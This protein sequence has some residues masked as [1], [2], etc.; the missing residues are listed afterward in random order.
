MSHSNFFAE[1]EKLNLEIK[2][3]TVKA[4]LSIGYGHFGGSLSITET[5]A[6][7]YGRYLKH[8]PANPKMPDRD[9]F[10]LSKGHAGPALYATLALRNFISKEDLAS[11]NANGTNL[12]SHADMNKTPGIDMTTGSL[13]QGVSCATGMAMGT[14]SNVFVI[15]GDGELQ[16]GQCWEAFQ[17]A[18]HHKLSNLIV[19]V[20]N[21]KRQLDGDLDE[22]QQSYDLQNKFDAFGFNAI[23]VNGQNINQICGA[24]EQAITSTDKPTAIIL[25]TEK[26]QGIPSIV[27]MK[28]NHHLRIDDTTRELIL[29]DLQVIEQKLEGLK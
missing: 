27:A 24:I 25:D 2:A 28:S 10:V 23:D 13:G 5:L 20:D 9:Y 1:I 21:N 26:G 18:A 12:P 4:L 19:F 15:V 17:F 3:E 7:L 16:E 14:S 22:I 6:C 29:Q 11:I 8:D